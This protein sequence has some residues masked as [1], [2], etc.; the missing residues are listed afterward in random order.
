MLTLQF[1]TRA[2]CTLCV[3]ALAVVRRV[4]RRYPFEL[5]CID[6]DGDPALHARYDSVIPVVTCGDIELACSFIE[7]KT[8]LAALKKFSPN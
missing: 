7:E 3:S 2:S 5:V 8:L 1:Y 4:Q 6:I